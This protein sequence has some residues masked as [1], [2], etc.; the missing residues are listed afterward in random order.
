MGPVVQL[1]SRMAQYEL[2]QVTEERGWSAWLEVSDAAKD[3]LRE[4]KETLVQYNGYPMKN[5]ATA[6][7]LDVFIDASEESRDREAPTQLLRIQDTTKHRVIAGDASAV[8]TCAF[9]VGKQANF[10]T[11]YVLEP[12]EC[13]YSS[14]Q[15]EL[16]TVLRALQQEKAFFSTLRGQ[17]V[18]WITDST[19]LVTFLTKGTMKMA[20]QKQILAAYELLAGYNIRIIPVHLKRT[21][22]RIQWADEG[23]REFDPDDWTVDSRTF[24]ELTK[25]WIPTIDLFAHSSNAKV[26]R[27]YSY[28]NAPNTAGVDAFAQCWAEEI[29]WVCPPTHLVTDAIRKIEATKMMAIVVI[30]AWRTATFWNAA[31]PD[32]RHAIASCVHVEEVRPHIIRGKFCTNKLMQGRTS[33]PFLALYIKSRGSGSSLETGKVEYA[34]D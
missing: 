27:F 20:I 22:Y 6:K 13:S 21:D 17:T 32:G 12:E 4:M 23:S 25:K 33:F 34:K 2:A 11:Q 28:G 7:K 18:I 31:F 10:F 19:N 5:V 1:L 14:G 9:E 26:S 16:L 24:K 29:A 3:S 8:A 15:R 30:P